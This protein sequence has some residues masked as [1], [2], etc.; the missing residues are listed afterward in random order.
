MYRERC[1]VKDNKK[2][3]PGHYRLTLVSSRIAKAARPGQFVQILCSDSCDPL[4]PRPFSFLTATARDFSVLY[5][6]VGKGTH[7]L[8]QA[9][10]G[11]SLWVLGPLGNGF[12]DRG[13]WIVDRGSKILLVGGGVGIPP[14]YHLAQAL[15]RGKSKGFA[16]NISVFLGARSKAFLLCEKDFK[17]L[18][19]RTYAATDDGSKGRRG[20]VT[21]AVGEF[22]ERIAHS[23]ER[24]AE[25]EGI[26]LYGCGPTPMLKALSVISKKH[27][28]PCEISVEVPMACGFGVCLGCAVKVA[29]AR[30]GV[31]YAM[32]CTEGPVFGADQIVGE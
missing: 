5:H 21:E 22:L 27:E 17:K 16:R 4:L 14:L 7:L 9:K 28:V 12:T 2:V 6:V 13:S 20:L 32:A 23:A 24:R 25:M 3:A 30:Q 19:V 11:D 26:A 31:R 15:T 10:A 18:G 8:S 29:D 1:L